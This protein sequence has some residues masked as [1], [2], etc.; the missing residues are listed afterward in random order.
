[1]E[2]NAALGIVKPQLT[3]KR[4][5]HTIGVMDTAVQLAELYG[6]DKKKA[7]LAAIFHDYAKFRPKKEM[8]KLIREKQMP[9]DLL[10]HHH[11][12]WH[13]PVGAY[14]V[15]HE[16]GIHDEEVLNAIRYHTSGRSGMTLLEKIVYVA[17]YIEPG[18]S[19]TGVEEVRELAFQDLDLALLKTVSNTISFLLKKNRGIYPDTLAAY[20]DLVITKLED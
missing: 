7:E 18:R 15:Q 10:F 8:E 2:R 11:E 12:L 13:A 1:M 17:D 14:L 4:F 9:A 19:F 6:A 16:A 5:Q 3:E 20:N